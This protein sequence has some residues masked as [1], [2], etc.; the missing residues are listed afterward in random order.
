MESCPGRFVAA[1]KDEI[2][3]LMELHAAV[4]H[5]ETPSNW[6][7]DDRTYLDSLIRDETTGA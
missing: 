3:K 5:G 2:W 4:A 1:T 7:E 6:S